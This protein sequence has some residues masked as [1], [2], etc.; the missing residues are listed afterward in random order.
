MSGETI[1]LDGKKV[2]D[3]IKEE[4]AEQVTKIVDQGGKRPHLAAILVGDDGASHTYVNNKIKS[5][6]KV[7]FEYTLLNFPDSISENKLMSEIERI[8]ADDDIDGLIVQLPLPEHISSTKVTERIMPE[9]D[10]DGFTNLNYGKITS[11]NP[12][13]MPAT[14]YGIVEL[15]KRYDIDILGKHC[16]MVGNSRTV[17]APMSIIMSY[18][19][20]ATVTVCHIHTK[21]LEEH[22]KKADILIVATGKPGLIK[23]D[24]VKDGVIVVDVGITR[25]A[26]DDAPRGYVLKG[27]VEFDE[28][29]PKSSYITPVPGGVGPMTIASLLLN[30]LKASQSRAKGKVL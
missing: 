11:K 27:D 22:T 30:T 29:A 16:V 26:S 13:L 15:L 3:D 25:I 5:C 21:N 14:P 12:G 4:I 1:I 10:V 9:K 17:G 20:N 19:E 23:G 8:N 6:K 7:G 28:V 24:M 2:A 18:H